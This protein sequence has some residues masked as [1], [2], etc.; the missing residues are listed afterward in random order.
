M[1]ADKSVLRG[2]TVHL[3]VRYEGIT[4]AHEGSTRGV[5]RGARGITLGTRGKHEGITQ[6]GGV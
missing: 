5:M 2:F 3:A 4:G 6:Q 1:I